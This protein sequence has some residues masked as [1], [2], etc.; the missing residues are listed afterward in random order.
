MSYAR[1]GCDGSDVYVY[2]AVDGDYRCQ[3]C[4]LMPRASLIWH[5]NRPKQMIEH[6]R[7]HQARGDSVPESAL[8]RLWSEVT[9]G[10]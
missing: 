6:L 4:R 7:E 5:C 2:Q 9:K 3:G 1:K 10:F 8:E